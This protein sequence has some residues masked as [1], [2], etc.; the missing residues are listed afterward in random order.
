[1]NMIRLILMV[2]MILTVTS[3]PALESHLYTECIV[4]TPDVRIITFENSLKFWFVRT[5]NSDFRIRVNNEYLVYSN[6]PKHK[7]IHAELK[8]EGNSE[9]FMLGKLQQTTYKDI[10][11]NKIQN[12]VTF[13]NVDVLLDCPQGWPNKEM[14]P[15]NPSDL[16]IPTSGKE[17]ILVLTPMQDTYVKFSVSNDKRTLCLDNH[18]HVIVTAE[19]EGDEQCNFLKKKSAVMLKVIDEEYEIKILDDLDNEL[20]NISYNGI[21][22]F[23]FLREGLIEPLYIA[24][25]IGSKNKTLTTNIT[26]KC[27]GNNQTAIDSTIGI[28]KFEYFIPFIIILVIA[29]MLFCFPCYYII[30]LK[31]QL[32]LE[33]IYIPPGLKDQ[34]E[35][36]MYIPYD[37]TLRNDPLP[38]S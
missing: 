35:T 5:G 29:I 20:A 3:Q 22:E 12:T 26:D 33:K 30:Y 2:V 6:I 16:R 15:E 4:S 24:Q 1:M 13:S 19:V 9:L 25:Y 27:I 21:P 8:L 31:R 7:W 34:C 10:L 14:T 38:N 17:E 32:L 23:K 11:L 37:N 28:V 18:S 36:T